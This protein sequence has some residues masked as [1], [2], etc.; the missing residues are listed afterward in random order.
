VLDLHPE[1]LTDAELTRDLLGEQA[2]YGRRDATE[3]AI[4]SLLGA[5]LLRRQGDVLS[6]TRAAMAFHDLLGS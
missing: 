6:P 4:G 2:T 3:R 5:G 1:Q